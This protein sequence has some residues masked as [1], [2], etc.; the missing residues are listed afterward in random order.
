MARWS[1]VEAAAPELAGRARALF[2][3]RVHK[4]LATLR[5][6]G[7]PR[8][9]GTET[10]FAEGDLWVGSMWRS[11]KALDLLR[12]PR[13]SMHSGSI[14]PP[15]WSGDARVSGRVHE[16]TDPEMIG[17]VLGDEIPPGPLHLF[18]AEVDEVVVVRLGEPADHLVVESWTTV[19]GV[20]R[21][22]RR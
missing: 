1:E 3:S 21:V 12:D 7:S 4:T 2:D 20:R 16:I 19:R 18:R 11:A 10:R 15:E 9:T 5:K 17:R 22:E 14:D 13:F 6:D 8:I